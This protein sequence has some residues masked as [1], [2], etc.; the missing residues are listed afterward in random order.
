MPRPI[1]T[2]SETAFLA[3]HEGSEYSY[4][5]DEN[6]HAH[7]LRCITH[8]RHVTVPGSLDG[9]A[10]TAV[11]HSAFAGLDSTES[12]I[13]PSG[14]TQIGWNAF[15]NCRRL[16]RIAL[17]ADIDHTDKTWLADCPQ[18]TDIVLP[19]AAETIDAEFL[20]SC[21]PTRLV[22][23]SGTRS[24]DV[25][26]FWTTSLRE[27]A[28]DAANPYL[29]CDGCC[30][31]GDGGTTL[32]RCLVETEEYRVQDG[33]RTIA[34]KA[35]AYVGRLKRIVLPESVEIIGPLAFLNTSLAEFEAPGSLRAIAQRAFVRCANL[36][37]VLLN[38][39]LESIGENAFQQCEKLECLVIPA[40]VR[41]L[42][43]HLLD[44]TKLTVDGDHPSFIISQ[45]NSALFVWNGALYQREA[46]NAAPSGRNAQTLIDALDPSMA[47]CTVHPGTTAIGPNAFSYHG[48]LECVVLPEGLLDIGAG[49]FAGCEHL[50]SINLPS[51]LKS[52]GTRG[53][54]NTALETLTIPASLESLGSCALAIESTDGRVPSTRQPSLHELRIAPGNKRFYLESG[55]LCERIAD[56]A[57]AVLYVGPEKDVAIPRD[58]SEIGPYA[59]AGVRDLD[60]LFL[61]R[62]ITRLGTLGLA[63]ANPPRLL[64]LE[65]VERETG[66]VKLLS[67]RPVRD[68]YG[69]RAMRDAFFDGHIDARAL[70]NG[71]DRMALYS[72]NPLE[73]IRYML[74]RLS[75]PRLLSSSLQ[76]NYDLTIRRSV[77]PF[78]VTIAANGWQH[79][80]DM[81]ADLGYLNAETI[82]PAIDAVSAAGHVASTAYLISLKKKRWGINVD[83][84]L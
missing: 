47:T 76:A 31:Y 42:G 68:Q 58:V 69:M 27:V 23:G 80:F 11:A 64:E 77:A 15:A 51:T 75:N 83:Y 25:P 3:H 21:R 41:Q 26:P 10:V 22:I 46:G 78:C 56:Y 4:A 44:G 16:R 38:D 60:R 32:L 63:L 57:R 71:M 67:I 66:D 59:F 29:S 20:K 9:H 62:N 53:L 52:I 18:L 72:R 5:V 19:A 34:E 36:Q 70:A 13:L 81:M 28:V 35:F 7:I 40:S 8:E 43:Q 84:T 73:R 33:C 17:P 79:G 45:D 48:S 6:G 39:G 1:E 55:I 65:Y 24:I 2:A 74:E 12:L 30:L 54:F 49:A 61:H 50:R 37:R 14:I 82:T